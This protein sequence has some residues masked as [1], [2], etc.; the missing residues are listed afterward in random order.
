M[1]LK[2]LNKFN[3]NLDRLKNLDVPAL[4][5]A[6]AAWQVLVVNHA[7]A[8]HQ[9][10]KYMHP[11]EQKRHSDNRFFQV[12]GKAVNSMRPG[13]VYATP[14]SIIGEVLAGGPGTEYVIN[15][16]FGS[17]TARAFPFFAPALKG[18]A[19]NG[20]ALLAFAIRGGGFV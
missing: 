10:R 17:A 14:T 20:L 13:D 11:E 12:T 2:G 5:G 18:T 7:K 16:E 9:W 4:K 19:N 3:R 1:P 8:N 6:M 15:L